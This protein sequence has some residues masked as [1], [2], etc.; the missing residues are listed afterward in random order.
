MYL[1][2]QIQND[3]G[4]FDMLGV[5]PGKCYNTGKLVRFGYV[6]LKDN[7]GRF[8]QGEKTV[9][10]HEFHYYDSTNNG[11]DATAS[12]PAAVRSWECAHIDDDHWWGYAHLYYGSNPEFPFAFVRKCAEYRQIRLGGK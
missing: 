12:K 3:E 2:E 9:K 6:E 1:H 5:I 7:T 10:A 8:L 4:T 11:K